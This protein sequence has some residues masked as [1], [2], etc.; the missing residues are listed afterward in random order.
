MAT[1]PANA[2][3][4]SGDGKV[5]F[6]ENGRKLDSLG[7]V[8]WGDRQSLRGA[9]ARVRPE[10]IEAYRK[11][12]EAQRQAAQ[13]APPV[14]EYRPPMAMTGTQPQQQAPASPWAGVSQWGAPM[15]GQ[16]WRQYKPPAP[17]WEPPPSG[18]GQSP[19]Q[20]NWNQ[21]RPQQPAWEPPPSGLGQP[22]QQQNWNRY[23]P[24]RSYNPYMP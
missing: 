9:N 8:V 21:F 22:Q 7:N 6:D 15:E 4:V 23:Q 24:P 1:H 12:E 2:V 17:A 5:S 20:Q 14:Q 18:L 11:E 16:N 10:I 3:F 13:P 19:Q